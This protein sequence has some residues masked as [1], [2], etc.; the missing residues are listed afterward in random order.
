MSNEEAINIE[1]KVNKKLWLGFGSIALSL[2]VASVGFYYGTKSDIKELFNAH[3]DHKEQ[4]TEFKIE[5]QKKASTQDLQNI[6][7][8]MRE[9]RGSNQKILE[10]LLEK[11]K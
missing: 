1:I 6:Q 5:L 3:Q 4:M 7:S 8:D 10:I 9:I 11:Q 2:L